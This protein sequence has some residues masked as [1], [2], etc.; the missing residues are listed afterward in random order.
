VA[1][2]FPFFQPVDLRAHGSG[3][4]LEFT[5]AFLGASGAQA[6]DGESDSEEDYS[7][8][9]EDP[10]DAHGERNPSG[11]SEGRCQRGTGAHPSAHRL[12]DHPH[13]R[14]VG[15]GPDSI[16]G[17][18][19]GHQPPG[20]AAPGAPQSDEPDPETGHQ[21]QEDDQRNEGNPDGS[22]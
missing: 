19:D 2:R 7:H 18:A 14:S 21:R 10:A 15:D 13:P 3:E 17:D 12:D 6:V 5:G 11:G 22:R 16:E 1:L 20:R 8:G 4:L 9:H